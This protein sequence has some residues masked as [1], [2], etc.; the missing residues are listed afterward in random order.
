MAREVAAS[1]TPTFD[2]AQRSGPVWAQQCLREY[3]EGTDMRVFFT[4][5]PEPA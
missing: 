1:Q 4:G 3:D 2:P 5:A